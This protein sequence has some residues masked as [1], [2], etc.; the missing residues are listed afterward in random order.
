MT[1]EILIASET[2]AI[3]EELSEM[4]S[5]Y[6]IRTA[7][8]GEALLLAARADHPDRFCSICP[9]ITRFVSN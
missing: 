3:L 5:D 6:P 1:G 9:I 7:E 4:L 2:P 8:S